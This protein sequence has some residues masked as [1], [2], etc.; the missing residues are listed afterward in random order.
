MDFLLFIVIVLIFILLAMY[1]PQI[2]I[3]I[4]FKLCK[5]NK[6]YKS[7]QK[8]NKFAVITKIKGKNITYFISD[9]NGEPSQN[10]TE[11]YKDFFLVW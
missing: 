7:N 1:S 8:D 4:R 10:Y 9:P 5:V 2:Y 3:L 11:H 6:H